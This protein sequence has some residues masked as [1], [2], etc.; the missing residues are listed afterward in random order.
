MVVQADAR[1]PQSSL[2]EPHS[3]KRNYAFRRPRGFVE[4]MEP[5]DPRMGELLGGPSGGGP[6]ELRSIV[7]RAGRSRT[8]VAAVAAGLALAAG[9]GL[10]YG[11]S[12]AAGGGSRQQIVATAPQSAGVGSAGSS[13]ASG[14]NSPAGA[15]VGAAPSPSIQQSLKYQ[16]LFSRQAGSVDIR[17]FLQSVPA[18]PTGVAA[19]CIGEAGWTRFQAEVSTPGMV[20]IVSG[21]EL[22]QS[23]PGGPIGF[24]QAEILGNAE[25]DPVAVVVAHTA[26]NVAQVR[27]QFIGGGS[28]Q[29]A[30]VQGWSALAALY[31]GGASTS[32]VTVG[33]LTALDKAGQT[34]AQQTVLFGPRPLPAL[35]VN[36]APNGSG[37][38]GSGSVGSGSASSGSASSGS[39]GAGSS[40][41]GTVT[42]PP[43]SGT[44]PV[45]VASPPATTRSGPL[46]VP[47]TT[48]YPCK[49]TPLPAQVPPLSGSANAGSGG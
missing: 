13:Q 41:S 14:V 40:S 2:V 36:P 3:V 44:P 48:V 31:P 15:P 25:G 46:P 49:V 8:R 26:S 17:G 12:S 38:S 19:V 9:G 16:K 5:V 10:G 7:S 20:G 34:L 33:T 29:M 4:G 24:T 6:D 23:S 27:M 32:Q 28:D 11:I 30:P 45:S 21:F 37:A 22:Q 35:P 42:S 39:G 47:G 43:A 18:V 1:S